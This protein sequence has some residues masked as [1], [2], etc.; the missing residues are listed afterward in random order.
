MDFLDLEKFPALDKWHDIVQP[1][2]SLE[3]VFQ[4]AKERMVGLVQYS[5]LKQCSLDQVLINQPVLSNSLDSKDLLL[6]ILLK[7]SKIDASERALTKNRSDIKV[8]QFNFI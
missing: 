5:L 1:Q 8:L 3:E 4:A 2:I 7:F 6:S